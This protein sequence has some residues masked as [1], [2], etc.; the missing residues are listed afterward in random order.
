MIPSFS[1]FPFAL[2]FFILL[3]TDALHIGHCAEA[4]R[5]AVTVNTNRI[6]IFFIGTKVDIYDEFNQDIALS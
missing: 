4:V 1:P 2:S 3:S 6:I 5:V